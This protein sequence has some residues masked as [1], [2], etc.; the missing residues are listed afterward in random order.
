MDDLERDTS[1]SL[2]EFSAPTADEWRAAAVASLGGQP[3]EKLSSRTYE[4][5]PLQP[6]Y[7]R[8]DTAELPFARTLPGQP[9]YLRGRTAAGAT[10]HGWA[11]AQEISEH[12]PAAFN[13][14]LIAALEHGQ[15]AVT[16]RLD[17]GAGAGLR[18]ATAADA[19][20]ALRGVYLHGL[21]IILHAGPTALPLLALLVAARPAG[22]AEGGPAE[23]TGSIAADP[24]A[25]LAETGALPLPLASAYDDMAL[26]AQWAAAAAPGLAT[27]AVRAD[28]YHEAGGSAV[29]ELA[30]AL[31]TG[32]AYLRALTER[33]VAI[34]TAAAA[35]A[36]H[37]AIGGQFFMEVAK[38]RAAR[39]LWAQV[40]AA[41]GASPAAGAVRLHARTAR[42]NKSAIDR[43]VNMLRATTEALAAAVGGADSICVAPFDE[44]LGAPDDFSRRIARNVQIILQDEAHMK[45]LIDPAGGSYAVESLTDQLA[46]AAWAQFQEIER[47]GGMAAALERGFVQSSI[48]AVAGKRAAALA[49]RRDVL[50]GV[51]QFA[52]PNEKLTARPAPAVQPAADD[53]APGARCPRRWPR[54][55]R[56]GATGVRPSPPPPPG[57]RSQLATALRGDSAGALPTP[58]ATPLRPA[59]AA[60]PFEA[61]RQ[62]AQVAPRLFLANLGPPRQHKARADFTQGFFEVGGFQVITNNGF[63]TP[64]EAAAAALASGAPAVAICSTDETYPDLVPP[65][66]AAIKAAAPQTVVILAGRPAEQVEALRAAGVD[67]FVYFGA[68]ALAINGWLLEQLIS[69]GV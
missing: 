8:E 62:K 42:R 49:K 67:E 7:R 19:A 38:L 24:L 57:T 63:A 64:D 47:Q 48:A 53:A 16:I 41:F 15:T 46:R 39:L 61:L 4:D 66:V 1:Y 6:L 33:G 30:F 69:R 54:R 65:L 56:G 3:F 44:P 21:P 18:L 12:D 5:I 43:H 17:D 14:A 52:N 10:Q 50:V 23:L 55:R 36:L 45:R 29:H 34:D 40:V 26:V 11:I 37:F 35:V 2:D 60:A 58:T 32:A 22:T 13:A 20:A 27:V 9:P 28:L 25:A 68:D 51:N 31:A 59:R